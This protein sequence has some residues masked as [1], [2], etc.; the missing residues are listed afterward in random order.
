MLKSI[1]IEGIDRTGK[2]TL[3]DG[4][5]NRLG[6][7]QTIHYQKPEILA[8]FMKLAR[9]QFDLPDDSMHPK[10][11][12]AALK[13]YQ[14]QSFTDMFKLLSTD[15]RFIMNRAHLGE[16]VYAPRYRGYP[17]D[18]IFDI[19]K[20]FK[21]DVTSNFHNTTLLVLL[22]TSSFDFMKDDG[23]SFDFSQK[24]EEQMDFVRA[25]EKS[26]IK[27]KLMLDIHDGTGNFV[28][29]EK[30]VEVVIQSYRELQTMSHQIIEVSWSRDTEDNLN[31]H[32]YLQPDPKKLVY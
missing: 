6:Y 27:H 23:L 15:V 18:F 19:E 25:F 1:I 30:L 12:E 32:N 21:E 11:T 3:I 9:N 22:H 26:D 13:H 29:K 16:F 31:R 14:A 4:I 24:D 20:S 7:F 2:N 17:G 10:V 28:P 8:S 5:K